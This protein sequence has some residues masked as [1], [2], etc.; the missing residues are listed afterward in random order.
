MRTLDKIFV[1]KLTK[2]GLYN[3]IVDYVINDNTLDLQVREGYINIYFKGNSILKLKEDGTFNINKKFLKDIKIDNGEGKDHTLDVQSYLDNIP[4]IKNNVINVKSKRPTLE[5]EYE[6]LL[7]RSN[8]LNKNVNSEIFLTDRQ[9]T[10][11]TNNSRFDLSGFFWNTKN[12]KRNQTVPL[13]FIE[14]KYSLNTDISDI[15][16]QID[17]YYNAVNSKISEIAS[18]TEYLK[19][20]K[21]ELGLINQPKDRLDALK[22]LKISNKIEDAK[23]I[24]ALIDFNP[25]SNLFDK[26]KLKEL[27]YANQIEIFNCGLAVW[28]NYLIKL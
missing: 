23:F 6:Q 8:N 13:T 22:T 3:P 19:N 4:L 17:K 11:N 7:I 10:D 24:I 21:I 2:G 1:S 14:V 16:K 12:R 20:L 9:Y 15:D 25:N 18:E 26:T 5:I 27:S 28:S